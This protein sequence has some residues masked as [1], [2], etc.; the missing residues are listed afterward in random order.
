M[1]YVVDHLAMVPHDALQLEKALQSF[2]VNSELLVAQAEVV[3]SFDTGGIVVQGNHVKLLQDAL[4]LITFSSSPTLAFS[5]SPFLKW[6][7]P[8]L[9]KAAGL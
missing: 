6:Q 2:F 1:G 8:R 3:Q 4:E 5:K 9:T 7:L